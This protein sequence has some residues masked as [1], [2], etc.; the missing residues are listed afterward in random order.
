MVREKAETSETTFTQNWWWTDNFGVVFSSGVSSIPTVN[1]RRKI[2]YQTGIDRSTYRP[3]D[4]GD[5]TQ[6]FYNPEVEVDY[7]DPAVPL[8][9]GQVCAY[10]LSS[11]EIL[12]DAPNPNLADFAQRAFYAMTPS[13]SVGVQGTN[14]LL[15]LGEIASLKSTFTGILSALGH[16]T[17]KGL[18]DAFSDG[19]LAYSF[20]IKPLISDVKQIYEG[21]ISFKERL[22]NL[23]S[24][25]GKPQLRHYTEKVSIP[26]GTREVIAPPSGQGLW[27]ISCGAHVVTTVATMRYVYYL[28][29]LSQAKAN[30]YGLLDTLGLHLN[31]GVIWEAIPFSFVVD[32]FFNVGDVLE[33]FNYQ[34]LETDMKVSSFGVSRKFERQ[35]SYQY[36]KALFG[37]NNYTPYS[38]YVVAGTYRCKR[39]YRRKLELDPAWLTP[40][41]TGS[42]NARKIFLGS[43]LA[44]QKVR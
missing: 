43:L 23:H 2:V 31:A 42:L 14:F 39:Y 29:E 6:D 37:Q 12:S 21:L 40:E 16:P 10:P 27:K 44:Y 18:M 38:D 20:G 8:K 3:C 35:G 13:M 34:Y 36:R 1:F 11:E 19:N 17:R 25:A 15:E 30:L 32:W 24:N 26:I 9:K 7:L 4:H 5:F 28:P 33:Q 41:L 22:S